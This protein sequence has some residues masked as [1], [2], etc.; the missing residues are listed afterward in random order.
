MAVPNPFATA[1]AS[2]T[3]PQPASSTMSNSPGEA[4]LKYFIT[5]YDGQ[6]IPLIPADEL[7]VTFE[8]V[9]RVLS[10]AQTYGMHYVGTAG[11]AG[12]TFRLVNAP[13]GMQ[14]ST[15]QPGGDTGHYRFH[16]ADNTR[17]FQAPDSLARQAFA[18]TAMAASLPKRPVSA[19]QAAVSWRRSDPL[20]A[21]NSS[22][23]EATQNAI[24]AILRSEAGAETAERIGYHPRDTTPPP[25]G[26]MPDQEKKVYCTHWIL[27]GWCGFVQQGCRYKHEMPDKAK[28]V[29]IG[30][31]HVPTWWKEENATFKMGGKAATA[32]PIVKPEDWLNARKGSDADSE[33]S[34]SSEGTDATTLTSE[35]EEAVK[36]VKKEKMGAPPE[37]VSEKKAVNAPVLLKRTKPE[38]Q[39]EPVKKSSAGSSPVIPPARPSTPA[40]DVRKMSTGSDLI[41]FTP[42]LPTPPTTSITTT[43]DPSKRITPDAVTSKARELSNTKPSNPKA[44]TKTMK[45]FV[46][47][48]ESPEVHIADAKKRERVARTKTAR[49]PSPSK[50][51]KSG[52][53]KSFDKQ[54]KEVQKS[55]IEGLPSSRWASR[56]TAAG[57]ANEEQGKRTKYG[58]RIRRPAS[59]SPA[60][61]AKA[62]E[63]KGIEAA[64]KK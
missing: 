6:P 45:V 57:T 43:T 23:S 9:P 18:N 32:G 46:P 63:A 19:S 37:K 42:L 4:H 15:S 61:K 38:P 51:D 3:S 50:N 8:S 17:H 10:P 35:S 21:S 47:V 48:G 62:A 2:S 28:L 26:I 36:V 34:S 30:I 52:E 60:S 12:H 5:R 7:P 39:E 31:K 1:P 53:V 41:K 55:K 20:T 14:R 25:S 64:E 40:E 59:S 29:E 11:C 27:H 33:R 58:C 54:A 44:P 22:A 16:S 49:N 56:S 13:S 24:N